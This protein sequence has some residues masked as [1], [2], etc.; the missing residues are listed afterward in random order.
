GPTTFRLRAS[1]IAN[2]APN[3]CAFASTTTVTDQGNNL[4]SGTDCGLNTLLAGDLQ[5]SNP[6]FD[7]QLADHGG[8]TQTLALCGTTC[9]AVS[10]AVNH[11]NV[12]SGQCPST[13]QRG[14]TR[15]DTEVNVLGIKIA[16]L[17]CDIGAFELGGLPQ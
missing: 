16:E 6:G 9:P 15:P 17:F 13:D 8:P 11:I 1:I 14:G 2:N 12:L 5:N 3:N 4:E 7:G 10:P